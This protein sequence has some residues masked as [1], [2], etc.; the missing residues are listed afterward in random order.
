[1][2][3]KLSG[4]THIVSNEDLY[5]NSEFDEVKL[6][7]YWTHYLAFNVMEL[8][9]MIEDLNSFESNDYLKIKNNFQGQ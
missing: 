5:R 1:M 4:F 6:L 2:N 3:I 9:F 8:T 7:D